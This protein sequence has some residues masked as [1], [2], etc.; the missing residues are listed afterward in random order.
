MRGLLLD[1]GFQFDLYSLKGKSKIYRMGIKAGYSMTVIG[2]YW[3][4]A[5]Q[6]VGGGP[7]AGVEGAYIQINLGVRDLMREIFVKK[8]DG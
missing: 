6:K 8:F 2:G 5:G 3:S 1:L 7:D 4:M